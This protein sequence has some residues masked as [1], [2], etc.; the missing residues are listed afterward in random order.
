[1]PSPGAIEDAPRPTL[2]VEI[3]DSLPHNVDL[4]AIVSAVIV[5]L[6]ME[7]RPSPQRESTHSGPPPAYGDV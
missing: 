1:M 4:S 2:R 6:G 3:D 5:A 7:G